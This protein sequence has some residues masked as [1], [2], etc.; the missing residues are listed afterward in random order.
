M[1]KAKSAVFVLETIAIVC[2]ASAFVVRD[3]YGLGYG[4]I[5]LTMRNP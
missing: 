1:E 2:F 5:G 4:A 3:H